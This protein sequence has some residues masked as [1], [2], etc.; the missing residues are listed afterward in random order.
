MDSFVPYNQIEYPKSSLNSLLLILIA[1]LFAS[2]AA[3]IVLRQIDTYHRDQL[4]LAQEASLPT[5][6]APSLFSKRLSSDAFASENQSVTERWV[7]YK[8]VNFNFEFKCPPAWEYS[9]L[10]NASSGAEVAFYCTKAQTRVGVLPLGGF[11]YGLPSEKPKVGSA[12]LDGNEVVKV[13]W[14]DWNEFNPHRTIEIY[15][16]ISS[17]NLWTACSNQVN[18][19]SGSNDCNRIEILAE[20]ELDYLEAK[21][22]LSTFKF[23]K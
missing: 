19:F 4:Y 9:A 1:T 21:D 8:A 18:I 23:I 2:G 11:G 22:I 16:F 5:H 7:S 12:I 17:P 20:T 13:S 6:K 15:K 14:Y 10:K 3:L